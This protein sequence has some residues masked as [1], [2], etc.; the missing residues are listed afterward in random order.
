QRPADVSSAALGRLARAGLIA[1]SRKSHAISFL[2]LGLRTLRK[3]EG[4]IR[5]G[6]DGLGF[7]EILIADSSGDLPPMDLAASALRSYRHLPAQ[8]FQINNSPAPY[9]SAFGFHADQASL[10]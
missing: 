2:P 4:L 8:F 9:L 1:L 10:E 3:L 7:Q 5:V 6:L